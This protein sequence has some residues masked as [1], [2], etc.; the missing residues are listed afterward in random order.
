MTK[1]DLV[2]KVADSIG[3]RKSDGKV[4]V[5]IVF[6]TISKALERG[7]H[8][9]LRGFG[10]FDVRTRGSW[11]GRNPQTGDKVAVPAKKI[12]YFKPGKDM[13]RL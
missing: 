8:V 10:S 3:I 7:E 2:K 11:S 12:P 1:V 13:K 5:D 4:V 9:E 6:D